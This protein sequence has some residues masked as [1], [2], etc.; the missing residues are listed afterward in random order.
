MI[1]IYVGFLFQSVFYAGTMSVY[2]AI[3]AVPSQCPTDKGFDPEP[4][5]LFSLGFFVAFLVGG[6]LTLNYPGVNM[7][8]CITSLGLVFTGLALVLPKL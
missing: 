6:F 7:C 3:P 8:V 5:F 4:C 2:S 1:K